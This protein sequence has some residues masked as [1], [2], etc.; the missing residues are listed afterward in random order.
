MTTPVTPPATTVPKRGLGAKLVRVYALQVLLISIAAVG[1][2]YITYVIV[3]D[4]VT[5]QAL[6]QEAS[7]FWALHRDDPQQALPNTANMRGYLRTGSAAAGVPQELLELQE[8]FG[9]AD[10]LPDAPLV[11][12]SREGDKTLYLVFAEAQVAD[13]VFFFGLA[14]LAAVLITV[15]GL[16]FLTYRLSHQA[17]SPMLNLARALERFDFR[18]TD[19]LKIPVQPDDVDRETRVMVES[20]QAFSG[21]LERFIERERTFTR[22]AGHELRTPMAVIKGSLDL[23]EAAP[24][25]SPTDRAA[26]V[27]M[28]RVVTDMETLLQTLLLLAREEEVFSDVPTSLNQIIAEEIELHAHLAQ[29]QGIALEFVEDVEATCNAREQVV[30]IIFGNLIRNALNYTPHGRVTVRI[31]LSFVA[32]TD[33]G[34]GMS[35]EDAEQAFTAFYRGEAAAKISSGQGLGLALVRR[36]VQQLDWRVE[37]TS[38]VGEGTEFR[39]WYASM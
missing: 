2:L 17:I 30:R 26:L 35:K 25:G 29:E 8:G 23:L 16:L 27:R 6:E 11:H 9:R 3:V 12:V 20:L 4:V 31:N 32:V 5:R 15:Y 19:K 18:S 36:L 22:N 1:G 21:R 38:A 34:I 37:L 39:V 13:L 10:G 28:R 24:D 7:H 33:T 14:P